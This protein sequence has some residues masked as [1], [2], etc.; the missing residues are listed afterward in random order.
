MMT[1]DHRLVLMDFGLSLHEAEIGAHSSLAGSPY[2]MAPEALSGESIAPGEGRLLDVY[3]LGVTAYELLMGR[4]PREGVTLAELFEDHERQLPDIREVRP[5]VP[6]RLAQL[7]SRLL[8]KDPKQRPPT[9]ESVVWQLQGIT[10]G[11][12]PELEPIEAAPLTLLIVDD[13]PEVT[14]VLTFY[15]RQALGDIDV[16][17]ASDG[18]IAIEILH[19]GTPDVMLLDL[20][21][22]NMNGLEVCMY[23]RGAN[24]GKGAKVIAVSAGAQDEDRQLLHEL[25][26]DR[27]VQKGP[28][29]KERLSEVLKEVCPG[30]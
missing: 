11:P 1:A 30:R 12:E 29:L 20:Q 23:M 6:P 7:V 10:A 8:A 21:M 26:I 2:Y 22:P 5:D 25:G 24:L 3:A 18:V 13:D 9:A 17:T 16:L 4:L 15:A 19:H 14:K 28:D 27:F